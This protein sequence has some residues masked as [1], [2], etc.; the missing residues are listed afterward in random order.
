MEN[1]KPRGT[2]HVDISDDG[3]LHIAIDGSVTVADLAT[4]AFYLTHT[5]S[6]IASANAIAAQQQG[7]QVARSLP[8]DIPAL[9]Q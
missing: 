4:A 2:I 1:D 8:S 3:Q 9:R 5:A 6:N 7:L